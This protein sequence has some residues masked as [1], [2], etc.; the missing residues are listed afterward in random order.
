MEK[1]TAAQE[2]RELGDRLMKIHEGDM[3][4]L[5]LKGHGSELDRD[6]PEFDPTSKRDKF[7][8]VDQ[9]ARILDSRGNPNPIDSITTKDGSSIKITM[10]Q[11]ANLLRLLKRQTAN[12][13]DREEKDQF[14]K[15]IETK[16]GLVP[17]L[18]NT[19]AKTMQSLYIKKY[20]SDT[21]LMALKSRGMPE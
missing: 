15:D 3:D 7:S 6:E 1:K 16:V 10:D 20:M 18:D 21:T 19:D 12:F 11:A 5:G 4:D 17:F 9:L 13:T 8:M 14:R 2:I